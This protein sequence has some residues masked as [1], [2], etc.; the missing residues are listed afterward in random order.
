MASIRHGGGTPTDPIARQL[1]LTRRVERSLADDEVLLINDGM[2]YFVSV[3]FLNAHAL[4]S[5]FFR[6]DRLDADG[7]AR[8][9]QAER[10]GAALVRS[11]ISGLMPQ[12][13]E[14]VERYGSSLGGDPRLL[15]E[16]YRMSWT[17]EPRTE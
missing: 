2:I 12:L 7:L 14:V 3:P 11:R 16:G 15:L 8:Q 1:A 9:L 4:H 10:V 13:L 6:Y 17:D 5:D